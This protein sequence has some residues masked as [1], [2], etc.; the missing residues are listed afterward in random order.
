MGIPSKEVRMEIRHIC[1]SFPG[2]KAVNDVSFD[3][4]KGE[5]HVLI[6]E[7]GAGKSTLL[8]MLAGIYSIDAGEI[9][10]EGKPYHP[11]NVIDAQ[12]NG[13][14]MIHQELNMMQNRTV[15]QNVL[16]AGNP[17]AWKS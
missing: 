2:V 16:L 5:I 10:L 6:G 7:N 14:A 8:K 17:T 3:I 4:R 11:N 12:K 9:L 13:V 15:A 1:K